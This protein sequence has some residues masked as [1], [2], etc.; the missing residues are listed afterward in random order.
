MKSRTDNDEPNREN[1]L[2]DMDDAKCVESMTDRENSEP[3]LLIPNTDTEDPKR[4]KLLIDSDDPKCDKSITDRAEPT[5]LK[6]LMDNDEP[7]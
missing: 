1:D 4:Q 5:R 7:T 3:N 2:T 6:L